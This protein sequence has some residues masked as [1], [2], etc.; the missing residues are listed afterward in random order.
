MFSWS[1][2][3]LSKDAGELFALLGLCPGPD[4]TM[5]AAASLA[6]RPAAQVRPLVGELVHAHLL[7]EHMTGRFTSHDLLR[8]YAAEQVHAHGTGR[9]RR[10]A[11]HRML[12]HYL[13]TAQEAARLLYRPWDDLALTVPQP[14]VTVARFADQ[15][16]AT[17]W[18]RAEHQV[19][20]GC[21]DY[22]ADAGFERH[23]WQLA[24]TM[25]SYFGRS[26]YWPEWAKVQQL[27]VSAALRIADAAAAAVP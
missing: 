27:A 23:A 26:G 15:T 12:D 19:L 8:A 22:A 24:R 13:H 7:T 3:A 2:A 5:P 6:G 25:A 18:L 17:A 11:V 16:R 10:A 1:T 20:L 4:L 9:D 14:G 21:I